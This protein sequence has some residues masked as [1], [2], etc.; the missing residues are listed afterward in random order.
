MQEKLILQLLTKD[1]NSAKNR[2]TAFTL[3]ELMIVV[4]I[5]G[6][7]AAFAIPNYNRAKQIAIEKSM[8]ANIKVLR[9]A[10]D[11]YA[12]KNH[13]IFD[14]ILYF[15]GN[16]RESPPQE[17][18]DYFNQELNINIILPE[19]VYFYFRELR[20]T[21]EFSHFDLCFAYS[22]DINS[23]WSD[24]IIICNLGTTSEPCCEINKCL[25]TT[26]PDCP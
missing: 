25:L 7:I 1:F 17:A 4:V 10:L 2:N 22:E 9:N 18:M 23:D 16:F 6:I 11:L 14:F 13:D 5:F 20:M 26:L 21:R 24:A 12:L 19:N 3:T 15:L 8:V